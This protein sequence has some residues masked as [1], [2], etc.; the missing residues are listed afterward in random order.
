MQWFDPQD[1]VLTGASFLAPPRAHGRFFGIWDGSGSSSSL[2]QPPPAQAQAP[3]YGL[4]P[5][6]GVNPK[7]RMEFAPPAAPGPQNSGSSCPFHV[8]PTRGEFRGGPNSESDHIW[9][10]PMYALVFPRGEIYPGLNHITWI[11]CFSGRHNFRNRLFLQ[12]GLKW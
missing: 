1:A 12:T 10:W 2:S 9:V 6:F 7:S 5:Q 3:P 8:K 11:R 4:P